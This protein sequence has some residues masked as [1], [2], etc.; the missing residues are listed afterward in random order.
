MNQQD[1]AAPDTRGRPGRKASG[2][3]I[4]RTTKDG[5]TSFSIRFTAYGKRHQ[6]ALGPQVT[7]RT[8]ADEELANI[9]ADVRRGTW[10]PPSRQPVES[11][12]SEPTFHQFAS[13]WYASKESHGLAE[14]TLE[15]LRWGLSYHLLPW[16]ENHRLSEITRQEVDRF[17]DFKAREGVLAPNTINKV[18]QMLSAVLETAVEYELVP[19]NAARGR[20]RRLPGTKPRRPFVQPEQLM[21]LIEAAE[22]FLKGRGRPLL[23]VLA[24][25]GLRIEEALTLT[26][27]DVDLAR[28]S[29]SV[30]KS[31]T[32]AGVRVVDLTPALR[33]ELALWLDRLPSTGTHRPRLPDAPRTQG[34]ETQRAQGAAPESRREGQRETDPDG[35][36]ADPERLARMPCGGRIATLRWSVR[37]RPGLRREPARA[38]RPDVHAACV[39]AGSTATGRS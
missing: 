21:A 35:N 14:R 32:D 13:E 36:R 30:V 38:H 24:G 5:P 18:L 33:D 25:A 7:T 6:L 4:V 39:R 3:V 34:Y 11:A 17:R 26:R 9:L 22:P 20:N 10:R 27:Q 37:R 31:K 29:L 2:Q 16:F 12:G 28:G 23:A 1:V 15:D 19:L 8:Q